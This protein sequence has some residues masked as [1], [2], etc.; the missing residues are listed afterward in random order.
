MNMMNYADQFKDDEKYSIAWI[1]DGK[2][3]VIRNPD[4]FTRQVLPK[5]FKAT[6]FQSFTRKLYRWGFRQVNRGIGP[7]DPI[8]FGN[9]YF[10]RDDEELMVKM[11]SVTAAANRRR[12]N[13]P[14]SGRKR[15]LEELDEQRR[16]I[17]MDR[18]VAEN[19]AMGGD[20]RY[21]A[22]YAAM[23]RFPPGG[24]MPPGMPPM[25]MQRFGPPGM[26]NMQ[27]PTQGE[28]GEQGEGKQEEGGEGGEGKQEGEGGDAKQ[29][30]TPQ[31]PPT[32]QGEK[33][34]ID[35]AVAALKYAA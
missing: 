32:P 18:L 17:L 24:M 31:Q 8:I 30:A 28:G 10:Q 34:I 22:Q 3:F 4:V 2:S 12:G 19:A 29:P 16:R 14:L 27:Q 23:M 15:S 35:S 5:F 21:M 6:K 7:D 26:F 25:M 1:P 13:D 11:R 9:E 33:E 20:P